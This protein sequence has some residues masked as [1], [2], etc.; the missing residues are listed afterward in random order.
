MCHKFQRHLGK[1][2][3]HIICVKQTPPKLIDF[4]ARWHKVIGYYAL[5]KHF[6]EKETNIVS[7]LNSKV[8]GVPLL[9]EVPLTI[10]EGTA[11]LQ[12]FEESL[13]WKAPMLVK[14]NYWKNTNGNEK[15]TVSIS[16]SGVSD[17]F[18]SRRFLPDCSGFSNVGNQDV[19]AQFS[20]QTMSQNSMCNNAYEDE[21][22]DNENSHASLVNND[23]LHADVIE[24]HNLEYRW[25]KGERNAFTFHS[26]YEQSLKAAECNKAAFVAFGMSM[27]RVY[28]KTMTAVVS[29]QKNKQNVSYDC[30]IYHDNPGTQ[31]RFRSCT[32]P[33]KGK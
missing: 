21:D 11:P 1:P 28:E 29:N 9:E 15:V 20:Q 26:Y 12:F 32:S 6:M 17:A 5:N 2:C 18:V 4:S 13:P 25:E 22:H 10:H 23:Q 19:S 16:T 31:F 3:V 27:R 8:P 7:L 24:K 14:N 30:G 33:K